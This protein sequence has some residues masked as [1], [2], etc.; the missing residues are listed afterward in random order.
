MIVLVVCHSSDEVGLRL[1]PM[2]L[3]NEDGTE[4][5]LVCCQML[6]S[7]PASTLRAASAAEDSVQPLWLLDKTG[8][9]LFTNVS[10]A[11]HLTERGQSCAS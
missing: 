1:Q 5:I 11:K 7:V 4:E 3:K 6:E 9:P 2:R 8:R 10:A